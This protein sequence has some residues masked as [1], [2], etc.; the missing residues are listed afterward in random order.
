[1]VTGFLGMNL[2]ADATAAQQLIEVRRPVSTTSR[3]IHLVARRERLLGGV[4]HTSQQS[5]PTGFVEPLNDRRAAVSFRDASG[6]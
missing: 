6:R 4:D 2:L 3:A 5:S 1:M